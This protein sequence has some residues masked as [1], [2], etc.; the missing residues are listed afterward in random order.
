MPAPKMIN[1]VDELMAQYH[2]LDITDDAVIVTRKMAEPDMREIGSAM[3]GNSFGSVFR[4][5]YNPDLRGIQGL[6]KYDKMRRGDGQV[7]AILR[8][9][10]TP[11]LAARWFVATDDLTDEGEKVRKFVEEALFKFTSMSFPQLLTEILLMLDFGGYAFEKVF[12]FREIDGKRRVIWKKFAPRHPMDAVQWHYDANGGPDFLEMFPMEP[13]GRNVEIDINKL[14]VFTY[15]KEAGNMEGMAVLRSVYKHWYYKENL[16]KIDA[17]QKERHGIGIPVVHLPPG[18][19]PNDFALAQELGRNLRTNEKSYA[20]ILPNWEI[21]TL[22]LEGNNVNAMQ[23]IDHHDTLMARTILGQFINDPSN[24]SSEDQQELFIKATRFIADIIRDVFNKYAIPELVDFNFPGIEIYPELRARR[25]GDTV[26]WRTISFAIRNFIG[27]Q[28]IKPDD[29][30]EKW[31]RAEMDLPPAD[32]ETERDV[33]D[34]DT[35]PGPGGAATGDAKMNGGAGA[36]V[37]LPKG[38]NASKPSTG[39]TGRIGNDKSGG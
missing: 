16:Y 35:N 15:E 34:A 22:K 21:S 5:E 2:V 13:T 18:F 19:T 12:D 23:S 10:K 14:I 39:S 29:E 20:V 25:I 17:I 11:V 38:G 31:V 27:A 8:L 36:R 26:D 30:L 3:P 37:G 1:G 7:R 24:R 33:F 28:V 4:E 9:I 32:A 6:I